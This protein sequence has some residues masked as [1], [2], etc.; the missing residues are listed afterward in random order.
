MEYRGTH[1]A[2]RV[3]PASLLFIREMKTKLPSLPTHST[4]NQNHHQK[5]KEKDN[6]SKVK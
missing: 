1:S 2:T 4:A 3:S 5:A 6:K